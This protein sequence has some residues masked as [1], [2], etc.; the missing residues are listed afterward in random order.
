M[1]R[2]TITGQI[3]ALAKKVL[4]NQMAYLCF[5]LSY[6]VVSGSEITLCIKFDKCGLQILGNVAM[7][8]DN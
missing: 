6:D 1:N 2:M 5:R 4:E 7:S 8:Y 3:L